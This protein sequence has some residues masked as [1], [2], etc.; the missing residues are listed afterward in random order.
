MTNFLKWKETKT[1]FTQRGSRDSVKLLSFV[2]SGSGDVAN[3]SHI[4][5]SRRR[6]GLIPVW[7]NWTNTSVNML[8]YHQCEQIKITPVWTDWTWNGE[9]R[10]DLNQCDQI[11]L[12]PLWT[13]WTYTSETRLYWYQSD[14]TGLIQTTRFNY[15]WR[16]QLKFYFSKIVNIFVL[17]LKLTFF[18]EKHFGQL[19]ATFYSNIS[20]QSYKHFTIVNYDS[21]VIPDLK[22]PHI[23]TLES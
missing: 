1:A 9:T 5:I 16:S 21:R 3:E 17:L 10:L 15:Y 6:L 14:K 23:S 20:G 22:I 2:P 19:K 18:E 7:P 13:D 12:T 8:D 11:R 4:A